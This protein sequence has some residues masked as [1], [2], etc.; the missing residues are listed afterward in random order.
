[1]AASLNREEEIPLTIGGAGQLIHELSRRGNS[2]A[3]AVL[4]PYTLSIAD[5]AEAEE[6]LLNTQR[7]LVEHGLLI[8]I[9]ADLAAIASEVGRGAGMNDT[10]FTGSALSHAIHMS[11][12]QLDD[13]AS[14][15]S[16]SGPD[17]SGGSWDLDHDF[18][19]SCAREHA[20][21]AK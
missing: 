12:Y 13:H 18:V 8:A 10:L 15:E 16:S 17:L 6:I 3:D 14:L 1:M 5:K 4:L 21:H 11:Q 7:V 9:N 19:F 20:L 2:S